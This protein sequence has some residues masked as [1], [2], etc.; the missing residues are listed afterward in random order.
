M[1]GGQSAGDGNLTATGQVS[2][3]LC[4]GCAVGTAAIGAFSA[5][6]CPLSCSADMYG[7]VFGEMVVVTTPWH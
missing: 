3:I 2:E 6:C 1:G 4:C 5:G 7:R